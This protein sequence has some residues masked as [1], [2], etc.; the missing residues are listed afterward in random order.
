MITGRRANRQSETYRKK[1]TKKRVGLFFFLVS[2]V[3]LTNRRLIICIC[4]FV[5]LAREVFLFSLRHSVI[6]RKG[7]GEGGERESMEE[8]NVSGE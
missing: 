8:I 3:F 4:T 6:S 5:P 1:N 2:I 7:G